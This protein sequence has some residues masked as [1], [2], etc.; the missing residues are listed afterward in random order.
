MGSAN[1]FVEVPNLKRRRL[2]LSGILLKLLEPEETSAGI[3]KESS[4]TPA[5]D[6]KGNEAI[7]IF[8]PGEKV[9]WFYQIFNAKS[10]ADQH[11][12]LNVQVRL[13]RDGSQVIES[14]PAGARFPQNSAAGY[15]PASAHMLIGL[16]SRREIT[17]CS[18]L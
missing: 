2:A 9:G 7:R 14:E 4:Q 1:Q 3:G 13:L 18:W 15:L 17:H 8:R 16:S 10:G 11:A 6:A 12:S 5:L